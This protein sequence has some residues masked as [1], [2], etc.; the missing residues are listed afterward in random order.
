MR[1]VNPHLDWVD[2]GQNSNMVDSL[3]KA[4]DGMK[5][6]REYVNQV[7]AALRVELEVIQAEEKAE[8]E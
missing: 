6:M 7:T 1:Q 8:K 4:F 3:P 2:C 5:A